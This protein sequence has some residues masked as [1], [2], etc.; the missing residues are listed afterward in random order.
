MPQRTLTLAFL[1]VLAA[2]RG[3]TTALA[4]DLDPTFGVSGVAMTD[5]GGWD[6]VTDVLVQPDGRVLVAGTIDW[7]GTRNPFLACFTSDGALDLDFGSAGL[8]IPGRYTQAAPRIALQADGRILLATRSDDAP[9]GIVVFRFAPDGTPDAGFGDAGAAFIPSFFVG[10]VA[11]IDIDATGRIVVGARLILP[12]IEA[13]GIARFTAEGA[14]DATFGAS[15]LLTVEKP[16]YWLPLAMRLDSADRVVVAGFAFGL[17]D[18]FFTDAFVARFTSEGAPDSSFGDE[19][20]VF[21]QQ[22]SNGTEVQALSVQTDGKIV[23]GG[24]AWGPAFFESR[25]LLVRLDEEGTPDLTFG[26]AGTVELD[27]STGHDVILSIDITEAGIHVAGQ[28]ETLGEGLAAARF[29]TSGQ[30]DPTFGK[31]GMAGV[32]GLAATGFNRLAVQADG[33]V[34]VAGSGLVFEPVFNVDAYVARYLGESPPDLTP[35]VLTVPASVMADATGPTGATVSFV[36]SATDDEDLSPAVLCAPPSG[37]LFPIGDTTVSCT[38]TDDAG[39]G[40]SA[41]FPV[42]V[43]GAAEQLAE[44][45]RAVAGVGPGRSLGNKVRKAAAFLAKHDLRSAIQTLKAF[46]REVKAQAGKSIP[47]ALAAE[48]VATATRII[49][50]LGDT[51]F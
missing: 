29:D 49:H 31:S 43:K 27:P 26:A 17:P 6:S 40:T 10:S 11:G 44:L 33:K 48:L 47:P 34:V 46:I 14:P 36:V 51:S 25:W 3:A 35:P 45:E 2:S 24:R 18:R 28:T 8:V 7:N 16:Y 12:A 19:G 41:G 32:P 1:V 20:I 13:V 23:A 21:I 39:N 15:G 9:V 4:D 37:S 30:L 5:V 22:P 50:V 42:H 38:A